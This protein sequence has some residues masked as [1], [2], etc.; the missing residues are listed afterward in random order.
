MCSAAWGC[1]ARRH[2][3]TGPVRVPAHVV[4][5][6]VA[7][8]VEPRERS[9]TRVARVLDGEGL[10]HRMRSECQADGVR[11]N[12]RGAY[13]E[14]GVEISSGGRGPRDCACR[15][16]V[17]ERLAAVARDDEGGVS[18]GPRSRVP[19]YV[20]FKEYH[21]AAGPR[22]GDDGDLRHSRPGRGQWEVEAARLCS[23]TRGREAGTR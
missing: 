11:I 19:G 2:L 22:V 1:A 21:D 4:G 15:H 23:G 12:P 14:D 7:S 9:A 20:E 6:L 10:A 13:L 3:L 5:D 16:R 17:D 8:E 18:G